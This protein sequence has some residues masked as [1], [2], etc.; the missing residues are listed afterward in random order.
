MIVFVVICWLGPGSLLQVHLD[1]LLWA[2]LG[3]LPQIRLNLTQLATELVWLV[4]KHT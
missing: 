3:L 1:L 2:H 4:D